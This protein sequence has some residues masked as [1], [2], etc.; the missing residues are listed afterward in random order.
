MATTVSPTVDRHAAYN[1]SRIFILSVLA[2]C[3]AGINSAIQTAIAGDLQRVFFDP[4]D[5]VHSAQK[6]GEILGVAFWVS[7][8]RSRLEAHCSITSGWA[9][10]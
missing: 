3:T 1:K 8:S 5:P 7:R 10:C 4:I 6:V 9:G 2:L